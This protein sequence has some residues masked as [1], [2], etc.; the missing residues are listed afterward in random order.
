MTTIHPMPERDADKLRGRDRRSH[1]LSTKLTHDE[2]ILIEGAASASGKTPSEWARDALLREAKSSSDLIGAEALMTE[3]VGLQL[4]LTD[5]LQAVACGEQMTPSQYEE[6]MRRV[7]A[8][9]HHAARAVI[10]QHGAEKKEQP[11]A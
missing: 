5:V 10:M 8:N 9:K 2:E 7:K 4:F 1:N 6:L 3:I 11:Y